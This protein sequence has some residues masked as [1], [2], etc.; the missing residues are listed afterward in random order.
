MR[1][2]GTNKS[3]LQL[4]LVIRTNPSPN[5]N[6]LTLS[7]LTLYRLRRIQIWIVSLRICRLDGTQYLSGTAIIDFYEG[8]QTPPH[9]CG[10]STGLP[11]AMQ[12]GLSNSLIYA[13]SALGI[14]TEIGKSRHNYIDLCTNYKHVCMICR[15]HTYV[16]E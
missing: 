6:W 9:P 14:Q 4:C 15:K 8:K 12:T 10:K 1:R 11:I 5:T 16:K 2:S 3:G 13:Y 7:Y